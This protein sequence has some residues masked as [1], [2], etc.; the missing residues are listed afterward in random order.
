MYVIRASEER[1]EKATEF[2]TKSLLYIMDHYKNNDKLAFI[3]IDF[4]NDLTGVNNFADTC[5]DIQ[6]KGIKNIKPKQLGSFL[7]TLYRNYVSTLNFT[8]FYLCID[9]LGPTLKNCIQDKKIFS[10]DDFDNEIQKTI[11]EGLKDAC[12]TKDYFEDKSKVNDMDISTF[13]KKVNFIILDKTKEEYVKN[14]VD[15]NITVIDDIYF[16]KVFK[17]IRDFQSSKKNNNLEGTIIHSIS[18]LFQYDKYVEISQIKMMIISRITSQYVVKDYKSCPKAFI[19]T[20]ASVDETIREEFLENCQ[21]DYFRMLVNINDQQAYWELF[22]NIFTIVSNNPTLDIDAIYN[23]L[24]TA[25]MKRIQF[26]NY[27]SC[28]YFISIIKEGIKC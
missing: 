22:E 3:A 8:E 6:S 15:Y 17:E 10:Y 23:K 25:K 14:A 20:L 12:M 13:L 11:L 28:R 16:K 2:E 7:V 18:C 26:L 21:N 19:N 27:N 9:S 5:Y 1:N 24:D 4:F